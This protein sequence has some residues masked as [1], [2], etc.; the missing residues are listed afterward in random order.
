MFADLFYL[1]VILTTILKYL[2]KIYIYLN[3]YLKNLLEIII[4]K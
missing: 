1:T 3:Y 4:L 2:S